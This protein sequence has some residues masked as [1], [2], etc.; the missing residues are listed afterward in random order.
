LIKEGAHVDGAVVAEELTIAG[1][2]KG[3]IRANRVKLHSTAVVEGDIFHQSISI[4]E[5]ARFEGLS[6]R[7]DNAG[8][9]LRSRLSRP[10]LEDDRQTIDR[11]QRALDVVAAPEGGS[12]GSAA[13][14]DVCP[15]DPVDVVTA[16]RQLARD[17]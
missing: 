5:N 16:E 3:T 7:E 4:E 8:D 14:Y 15:T 1:Q 12:R 6:K 11:V 2:V 9:M 17:A 10:S 13:A